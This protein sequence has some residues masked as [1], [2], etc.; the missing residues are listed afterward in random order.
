MKQSSNFISFK[1]VIDLLQQGKALKRLSWKG[2]SFITKQVE[3][4]IPSNIIPNMTSLSNDTKKI[5]LNTKIQN[6]HYINQCLI[7][8]CNEQENIA[9]HYIPTWEDI[10]ATDWYTVDV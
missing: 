6:I 5:L 10:F 3:A 8:T 4:V 2:N 9:T 1:E 7:V